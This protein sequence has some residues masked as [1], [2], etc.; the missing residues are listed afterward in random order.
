M[1]TKT[2]NTD[3]DMID[4]ETGEAVRKATVTEA[5]FSDNE[6]AS[7]PYLLKAAFSIGGR[8]CYVGPKK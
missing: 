5:E 8:L 6:A 2:N 7:F 1:D 4:Y 3:R